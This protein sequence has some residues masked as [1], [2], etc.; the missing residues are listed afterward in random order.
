[1]RETIRREFR[2]ASSRRAQPVWFRITKWL[3]FLGISAALLRTKYLWRWLL[4]ATLASASVHLVWR[5]KTQGWTRPW[6]GWTDVEAGR[7]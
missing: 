3:V 2:V 1:M 4:G 6:G 7:R 5:W